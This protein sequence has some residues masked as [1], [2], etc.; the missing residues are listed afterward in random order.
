MNKIRKIFIKIASLEKI[1]KW[2]FGE[3]K[4]SE[5]INYRTSLPEFGGLFCQRIFGP[6]KDY[7]CACGKYVNHAGRRCK[8]CGVEITLSSVRRERMGHIKFNTPLLNPLFFKVSPSKI[9]CLLNFAK[10]DIVSV[11]NC[12]SFIS[13]NSYKDVK[14]YCIFSK[15]QKA[16]I[17]MECRGKVSFLTGGLAIYK[18]L[19]TIRLRRIRRKIKTC[20]KGSVSPSKDMIYR[21]R[22]IDS[23]IK[24]KIRPYW[25]TIRYLPVLPPVLRPIVEMENSFAS[26]DINEHYRKLIDR[27]NRYRSIMHSSLPD[28]IINREIKLMQDA[29]N[30]LF[31]SGCK[32][33]RSN[34]I[35]QI[36]SITENLK[37]KNG[38]FRKNLLGKRVDYS[39]RSVIVVD[40]KLDIDRCAIPRRIAKE[41]FKPFIMR[42]LIKNNYSVN[43]KSALYEFENDQESVNKVLEKI[44]VRFRVILNRAPTLHR[45][46]MQAFRFTLCNENAIKINPMV[47]F[48]YNADFDGDQMAIHIPISKEANKECKLLS[49]YQNLFLPSNGSPTYFPNQDIILGLYL[50]TH[51][52]GKVVDIL[53]VSNIESYI[54]KRWEN[55][56]NNVIGVVFGN[57]IKITTCGR[58]M[59][60]NMLGREVEFDIINK[61]FC[62]KTIHQII[63]SVYG[64]Y[65]IRKTFHFISRL[66][67][68]GFNFCTSWG[69]T[70]GL[71]D[72]RTPTLK[73]Q[74]IKKAIGR[75]IKHKGNAIKIWDMV[76][77]KI[78]MCNQ[79][80]VRR[81]NNL[82]ILIRSG[83][84]S[85]RKQVDQLSA[86]RGFMCKPDG[87]ILEIPIISNLKEGMNSIE[88]F[89]STNGARKGLADTSIKTADSGYL[90]RKLV[91]SVHDISIGM[92]DCKTLKGLRLFVRNVDINNLFGRYLLHDIYHNG[93]RYGANIYIKD[94]GFIKYMEYIDIRSPIYCKSLVGVCAKCYGINLSNRKRS[95]VGDA[96][97]IIAAQ[98]IGEPGTQL[99]MRTFHIG[100]VASSIIER[101]RGGKKGY[102]KYSNN[103]KLLRDRWGRDVVISH[104][105]Y[106]MIVNDDKEERLDISYGDIV[107]Y[108]DGQYI[109]NGSV[110]ERLR[111]KRTV[112]IA[113]RDVR[114]YIKM[115]NIVYDKQEISGGCL[116]RILND[117]KES[118]YV[119]DAAKN[120]CIY[121]TYVGK[122]WY[123]FYRKG[124]CACAG[125]RILF[126]SKKSDLFGSDITQGLPEI[127]NIF[128]ARANKRYSYLAPCCGIVKDIYKEGNHFCITIGHQKILIREGVKVTVKVGDIVTKCQRLSDGSRGV[129][130]V[131]KIFGRSVV[132][133]DMIRKL[134]NVYGKQGVLINIKH[135]EVIIRKMLIF[136]MVTRSKDNRFFVNEKITIKDNRDLHSIKMITLVEGIT[137]ISSNSSLL[138]SISFQEI[139][140]VLARFAISCEK[141]YL[142]GLKENVILGN[143][144]PCGTGIYKNFTHDKKSIN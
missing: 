120:I 114:I 124:Y 123:I 5:T 116:V 99:T 2:S 135:F 81:G 58:V 103:I 55:N 102:V 118:L 117:V 141:D 78:N 47:C 131:C 63:I 119:Y 132:S 128:E 66:K 79:A 65:G 57:I 32:E 106:L 21:F 29:L 3:V 96:V 85:S 69:F 73:D 33:N 68:I 75:I 42:E 39:A 104:K 139:N 40:P 125:D 48:S 16:Q 71:K 129:N 87:E 31:L 18:M 84:K 44:I 97:G 77:R 90:T 98:S 15:A 46:G 130:D 4:T 27:N 45:L 36:R 110:I 20:I 61:T 86:I 50:L 30:A 26:S 22:I 19:K 82:N 92:Q 91:D 122:G 56:I 52:R 23:M 60:Y 7:E 133:N 49:P 112:Y 113:E 115:K 8:Y 93:R 17:D 34:K 24:N 10:K 109:E 89:L 12:E 76:I 111:G 140:K 108:G 101:K 35:R 136:K 53:D 38:R 88:Y 13:Q 143:H 80:H 1:L 51:K 28:D 14:K 74:I 144:I 95:N 107:R 142:C 105:G 41:I 6:I 121:K 54:Y 11:S 25:M 126:V 137:K 59:L 127:V 43:I 94:V 9:G 100:G 37:G 138:S 83:A 72:I 67:D 64:K 62:K 70:V 134:S